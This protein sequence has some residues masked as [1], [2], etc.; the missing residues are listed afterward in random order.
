MHKSFYYIFLEKKLMILR[1]EYITNLQIKMLHQIPR[2][3][4]DF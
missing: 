4:M 1:G 3:G 2:F